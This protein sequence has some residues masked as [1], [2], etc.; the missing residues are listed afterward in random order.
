[1]LELGIGEIRHADKKI[2][3]LI[4]DGDWTYGGD[5]T[6]AARLFDSLHV[7]GCQEPLIYEDTYDEFTYYQRRKS[8]HGIKIASLAKEGRG[9]FSWVE[10]TDDVP[11]AI[12]RC[13]TATA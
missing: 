10:S 8:Y 6:R 13:L 9:R 12:S 5:P 7:I 11:G 4:T 3:I 2:G 1:A